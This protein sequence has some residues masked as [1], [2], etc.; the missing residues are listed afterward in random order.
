MEDN[1]GII[2]KCD[3]LAWQ[4]ENARMDGYGIELREKAFLTALL[5]N[6]GKIVPAYRDVFPD[7]AEK[8]GTQTM[9]S[10]GKKILERTAVQEQM[11]KMLKSNEVNPEFVLGGIV[12][13]AKGA[14]RDADKLKG[15]ELLGKFLKLFGSADQKKNTFNINI[16][17]D[18]ARRLLERRERHEVGGRGDFIDVRVDGEGDDG[19]G[20]DGEEEPG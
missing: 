14:E 18:T 15:Y 20:V 11:K 3:T 4:T 2:R 7:E 12:E 5:R 19:S 13:I 1:K 6:D 10:R 16:N 17:E 8:I 9:L